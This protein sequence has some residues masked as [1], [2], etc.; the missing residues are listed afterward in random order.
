MPPCQAG[1][2]F[3]AHTAAG[4]WLC[5]VTIVTASKEAAVA[6]TQK[7]AASGSEHKTCSTIRGREELKKRMALNRSSARKNTVVGLLFPG[8]VPLPAIM[9]CAPAGSLSSGGML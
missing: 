6:P 7:A 1:S 4:P 5:R 9:E 3:A 2:A 8:Q